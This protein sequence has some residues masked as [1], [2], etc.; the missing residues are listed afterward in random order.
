MPKWD[1]TG[2]SLRSL[3]Q[4]QASWGEILVSTEEERSRL[5]SLMAEV[6]QAIARQT[7]MDPMPEQEA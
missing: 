3:I 7:G 1:F 5:A 6:Q 2:W 4:L